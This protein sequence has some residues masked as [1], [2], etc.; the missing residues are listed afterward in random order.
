[1]IVCDLN[2]STASQLAIVLATGA[3][4]SELVQCSL[5]TLLLLQNDRRPAAFCTECYRGEQTASYVS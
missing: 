1:M 2:T 3:T 5:T 4:L